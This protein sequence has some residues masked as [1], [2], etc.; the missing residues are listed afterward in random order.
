[1]SEANNGLIDIVE[2]AVPRVA[3]ASGWLWLAGG[4]VLLLALLYTIF[5]MWKYKLPAYRALQ[6]LRKLQQQRLAGELSP[7]ETVLMVALELRHGLGMKRLRSDQ[8]PERCHQRDHARWPEMMQQLDAML[9]QN[10]AE[11][12][13]DKLKDLFEQTAYWLRRYSRRSALK[14]ITS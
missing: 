2:P 14:K 7:H 6:R 11:Q 13:T 4:M 5:V 10:D 12:N 9:Y 3:E 1:M 8:L